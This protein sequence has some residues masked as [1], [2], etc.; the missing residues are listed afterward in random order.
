MKST[1]LG[2]L[3][4]ASVFGVV[5]AES[6]ESAAPVA[7][8]ASGSPETPAARAEDRPRAV[9]PRASTVTNAD[10]CLFPGAPPSDIKYVVIKELKVGKGTYGG[11]TDVLPALA[12]RARSMGAD[13][14]IEYAGS[15]RF[16]FW[17]WR[18]V[19]PV[20]SGVAIRWTGPATPD[21]GA[22]GGTTLGA[23]LAS[24]QAPQR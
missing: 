9:E 24:N 16:G 7:P 20:V 17:P 23:V 11:V 6:S 14:I 4:L 22:I 15:Q 12:A 19:R 1:A 3:I 5:A 21:C 13:A 18:M 2:M 8:A 10:F